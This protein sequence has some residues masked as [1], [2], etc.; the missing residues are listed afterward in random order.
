VGIVQKLGPG[1]E[2]STI[3]LGDRVG[4]KWAAAACGTCMPCRVGFD[5]HCSTL[6][7]ISGYEHLDQIIHFDA[8]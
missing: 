4:I 7:K 2:I 5:G 1:A 3:K 6:R 8:Y